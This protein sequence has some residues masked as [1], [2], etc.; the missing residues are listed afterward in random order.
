[1][2]REN[3]GRLVRLRN[4]A[5]VHRNVDGEAAHIEGVVEEMSRSGKG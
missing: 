5:R 3:D 2:E 4:T 1:M